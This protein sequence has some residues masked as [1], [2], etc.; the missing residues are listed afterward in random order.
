MIASAIYILLQIIALIAILVGMVM[1]LLGIRRLFNTMEFDRPE[2]T[3]RLK[4][5]IERKHDVIS[6]NSVFHEFLARGAA[7]RS[8]PAAHHGY[9]GAKK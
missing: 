1:L 7:R 9:R 4:S 8:G 5:E 2:E 6:D 3:E